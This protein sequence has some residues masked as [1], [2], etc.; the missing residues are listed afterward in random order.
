MKADCRLRAR[1]MALAALFDARG[2]LQ[3]SAISNRPHLT[4]FDQANSDSATCSESDARQH[5]GTI[6]TARLA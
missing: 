3:S 4:T 5:A 2:Q 1:N 6:G